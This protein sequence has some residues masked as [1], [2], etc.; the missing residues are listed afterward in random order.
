MSA[1]PII[2]VV[3]LVLAL[4]V[5]TLIGGLFGAAGLGWLVKEDVDEQHEGSELLETNT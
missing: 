1:G 2:I 4:P 5:A 3:V